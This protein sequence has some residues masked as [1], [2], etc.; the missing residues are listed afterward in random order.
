MRYSLLLCT[1]LQ[2]CASSAGHLHRPQFPAKCEPA[3]DA[4]CNTNQADA[5]CVT[6]VVAKGGKTPLQA[7]FGP[8]HDGSGNQLRCYSPSC[9]V[10]GGSPRNGTFKKGCSLYC[11]RPELASILQNCTSPQPPPSGSSLNVSTTNIWGGFAV[12]C[13]QIRTP[14]IVSTPSAL[15]LFGQC[16]SANKS[17]VADGADGGS[18]GGAAAARRSSESGGDSSNGNATYGDDMR[19][20]RIVLAA[21]TDGGKTWTNRGYVTTQLGTSVGVALYDSVRKQLVFQYQSFTESNP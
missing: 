8:D 13:G 16:R 5:S 3:M 1:T 19:S 10:D 14:E 12:E 6:S 15:L 11:A 18:S 20:V 4:W 7:A 2:V 17:A 21:S 9:F